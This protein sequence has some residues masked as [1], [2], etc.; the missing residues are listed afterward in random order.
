M[1]GASLFPPDVVRWGCCE[2]HYGILSFRRDVLPLP[3]QLQPDLS[4]LPH[5]KRSQSISS[6][7][8]VQTLRVNDETNTLP[9]D[10]RVNKA[11]CHC[12]VS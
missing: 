2:G 4:T 6:S 12:P 7:V 11:R 10:K 9:G 3:R 5:P 8:S 1:L